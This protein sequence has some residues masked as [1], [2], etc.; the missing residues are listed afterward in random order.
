MK[1]K[2]LKCNINL[3]LSNKKVKLLKDISNSNFAL[4]LLNDLKL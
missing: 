4:C 2:N 1:S 3:K